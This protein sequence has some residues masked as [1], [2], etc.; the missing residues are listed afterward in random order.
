MI[1]SKSC[2]LAFQYY[3]CPSP[4]YLRNPSVRY[5][6]ISGLQKSLRQL[7]LCLEIKV[8]TNSYSYLMYVVQTDSGAHPARPMGTSDSSPGGKDAGE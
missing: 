6:R 3:Y 7:R 2:I 1:I 5:H 8:I 4:F